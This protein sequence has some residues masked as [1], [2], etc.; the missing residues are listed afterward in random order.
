MAPASLSATPAG[1]GGLT[2]QSVVGRS[3][4]RALL[5]TTISTKGST[6]NECVAGSNITRA[7]SPI[8]IDIDTVG[9]VL[10]SKE[11]RIKVMRDYKG[12]IFQHRHYA[13]IAGA[14]AKLPANVSRASVV[15]AFSQIFSGDNCRFDPKRFAAAAYGEPSNKKDRR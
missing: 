2:T 7:L 1:I 11:E 5:H 3:P 12:P 15:D 13:E 6:T 10:I 14:I 4:Q 9:G 8:A